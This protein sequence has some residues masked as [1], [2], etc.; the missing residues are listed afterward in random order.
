MDRIALNDNQRL[1]SSRNVLPASGV[2]HS[3]WPINPILTIPSIGAT[4]RKKCAL[5]LIRSAIKRLGT[6]CYGLWQTTNFLLF[7][8][9]NEPSDSFW[10]GNSNI[11][12]TMSL[13]RRHQRHC[14]A[15]SAMVGLRQLGADDKSRSVACPWRVGALTKGLLASKRLL[16][17]SVGHP[18][19]R[20]RRASCLGSTPGRQSRPP[21]A[22][23]TRAPRRR[24]F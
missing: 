8:R 10:V 7:G 2:R 15:V 6:Q 24:P 3:E 23:R 18:A 17:W 13:S 12:V 1:S 22:L 5:S 4:A 14:C 9:K 21:L 11:P 20:A 19:P 16:K